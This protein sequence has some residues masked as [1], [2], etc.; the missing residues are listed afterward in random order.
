MTDILLLILSPLAGYLLASACCKIPQNKQTLWQT[1]NLFAVELLNNVQFNKQS[2]ENFAMQFV[3]RSS[4][5]SLS[6]YIEYYILGKQADTKLPRQTA[7]EKDMLEKFFDGLYQNNAQAL[8]N[9]L[10]YYSKLIKEHL[11]EIKSNNKKILPL[12]PKLGILCGIAVALLL[13]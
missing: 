2:I 13:I 10:E 11:D 6:P 8:I 9:H 1:V 3:Q 4:N 12:Y 7:I 5:T